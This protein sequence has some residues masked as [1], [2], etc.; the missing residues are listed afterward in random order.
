MSMETEHRPWGNYIVFANNM[1]DNP[2][3]QMKKLYINP[4]QAISLQSHDHR[5]EYWTIMKG[6]GTVELGNFHSGFEYK[7]V[8]PGT[9]LIIPRRTLHRIT[10]TDSLESLIICEVQIGDKIE[11]SDITRYEDRYG[12]V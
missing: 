2:K 11:E 7:P 9:Q 12:R 3:W 1:V 4:G 5:D 8:M 6:I 10:N